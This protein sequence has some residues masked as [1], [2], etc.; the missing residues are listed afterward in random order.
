MSEEIKDEYDYYTKFKPLTNKVLKYECFI[1]TYINGTL[2]TG[3]NH[4]F[5][6]DDQVEVTY[7]F[8]KLGNAQVIFKLF[9]LL[10]I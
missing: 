2:Q 10:I 1:Y 4:Q 3:N 6:S 7:K 9:S 8:K 5:N